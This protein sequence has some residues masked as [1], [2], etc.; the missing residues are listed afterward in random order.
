MTTL[1]LVYL[2]LQIAPSQPGQQL[3]PQACPAS[4]PHIFSA[5]L[6]TLTIAT[7][8]H[9][10]YDIVLQQQ[11]LILY[12]SIYSLGCLG[13]PVQRLSW[14]RCWLSKGKISEAVRWAENWLFRTLFQRLGKDSFTRFFS[15]GAA[16]ALVTLCWSISGRDIPSSCLLWQNGLP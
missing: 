15:H 9:T 2:L 6:I 10:P 14:W 13:C 5:A 4:Q 11:L 7:T 1:V 3:F 12:R 16:W 8:N